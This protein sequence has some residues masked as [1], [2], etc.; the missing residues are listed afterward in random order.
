MTEL[1]IEDMYVRQITKNVA[2]AFVRKHH[3]TKRLSSARYTLGLY[4]KNTAKHSFFGGDQSELIGCIVYGHP[5]SN[6]T[7]TSIFKTIPLDLSAVLEL[8]R[9]VVIDGTQKNTET[10]FIGQSFQWLRDNDPN[11]RVLISYADP[12]QNHT[13]VIYRASNW[14]YQGCGAGKLMA[15][16][17]VRLGEE[18]PWIHS[19]TVG[20]MYGSRGLES[21]AETIGSTFWQKQEMPK[22]R[23]IYFLCSAKETKKL[24]PD[25][26]IPILP[27][28]QIVHPKQIIR[29]INVVDGKIT[30]IDVIQGMDT[31]WKVAEVYNTSLKKTRGENG[32]EKGSY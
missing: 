4:C 10:W 6:A 27:Y 12:E 19:R 1:K 22:H 24:I 21:L 20:S 16:F 9:L 2:E 7:V 31:G 18:G 23:Y 11:V 32:Q 3:Y 13:G 8:T 15:D 28:S 25:L 26:V 29:K 30:G 14:L 17:S 5:V